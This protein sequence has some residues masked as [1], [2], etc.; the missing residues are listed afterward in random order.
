MIPYLINVNSDYKKYFIVENFVGRNEIEPE[1]DLI[2]IENE[3]IKLGIPLV[4][5]FN[6][7]KKQP[8]NFNFLTNNE[9]IK[10]FLLTNNK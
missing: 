5:Y 4:D 10:M 8:D 1:N 3:I 7:A 6:F 9:K 2:H